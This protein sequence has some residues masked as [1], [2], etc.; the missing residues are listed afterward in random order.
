[1]KIETLKAGGYTVLAVTLCI[2]PA[3][4]QLATPPEKLYNTAKQ[5][6]NAQRQNH[7][8]RRDEFGGERGDALDCVARHGRELHGICAAVGGGPG[9]GRRR[10]GA[11]NGSQAEKEDVE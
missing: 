6:L 10:G 5:K 3:F 7:R 1:M 4:G 8:D 11:A 2:A 9:R